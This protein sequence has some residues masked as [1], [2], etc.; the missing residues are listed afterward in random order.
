MF[1]YQISPKD[2]PR[3][4]NPDEPSIVTL[5]ITVTNKTGYDVE[6]RRLAFTVEAGAGPASLTEAVDLNKIRPQAGTG[7]R[8]DFHT[9][10]DGRFLAY[11]DYPVTGL[12]AGESIAFILSNVIIN[13]ALG[14]TE[15]KVTET[16]SAPAETAIRV[17]KTDPGL[18]ITEFLA[19]P[20]QVVPNGESVLTWTTT[21]ASRCTL[22][23]EHGGTIEVDRNGS[24]PEHPA[25]TTRYTLS[26]EGDGRTIQ[27]DIWVTVAGVRIADFDATPAEVVKGDPVTF[28]W[29][30]TG[31]ESAKL[32]PGGIALDPPY[33]GSHALPVEVSA[34]Y[35]LIARG[36][37]RTD[38]RSLP[39]TVMPAAISSFT[40]SPRI[41]P[42]G[43]Q[44]VLSWAAQWASGFRVDP[45]GQS[46]ER[47]VS[48]LAVVPGQS[49]TY[50]LTAL[51]YS[52]P[53]RTVTV[54]VGATIAVF[55]LTADASRPN[56][57]V[58]VWQVECGSAELEVWTGSGPPPG[59]PSPVPAAADKVIALTRGQLTNIRL[60]GVGSGGP[61]VAALTV[62]GTLAAGGTVL[63]SL[64][65]TSPSGISTARSD[66]S[67]S[68]RSAQGTL[69]GS[70]R[71]AHSSK[72]LRGATG[73]VDLGLGTRA[74]LS[75]LWNGDIYLRPASGES[76]D[77]ADDIGLH[78][79]VS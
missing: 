10:G 47:T 2:V 54:A 51:G 38:T 22:T 77:S 49:T 42:P 3:T 58:L 28:R 18:A 27:Q 46:L 66:V 64:A 65:M 25:V 60:A 55:G 44:V 14:H 4:V 34:S 15:I 9:S 1:E 67:V 37:G 73:Q 39:I 26:A 56:E 6:V 70:I 48:Q 63:E 76:G 68:W 7:T 41:V 19:R 75:P 33:K 36:Y 21:G 78:W 50:R 24:Q 12:L 71:D 23:S 29:L 16:T 35:T 45:P 52:E 79:E 57:M 72:D 32:D 30:V 62:S 5:M 74:G 53:D 11:P 13:R 43:T 59:K 31:V 20:V 69:T 61:A 17:A 40:A 8:W